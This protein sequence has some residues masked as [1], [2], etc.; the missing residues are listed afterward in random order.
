MN[1]FFAAFKIDILSHFGTISYLGACKSIYKMNINLKNI[2]Y[3]SIFAAVILSFW[4]LYYAEFFGGDY[5]LPDTTKIKNLQPFISGIA[6]PLMTFGTTLLVIETFKNNTLQNISNNFFKLID[7][8]R[9]I[10][11]GVN[12]DGDRAEDGY[13]KSK[14][15]NF[16]DDL[17]GQLCEDYYAIKQR[18]FSKLR[19]MDKSIKKIID[20]RTDKEILTDLYDHYFHVYQSDLGHY[21]RNLY[22]IVRYVDKSRIRKKEKV[23]FIKILRSQLSN[24]ELLILAYNGLHSYGTEFYKYLE[25]YELLKSLNN[26]NKLSPSYLKR[27]VDVTMLKACYPKNGQYW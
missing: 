5:H 16:F 14:G 22:Y 11:D 10:L 13:I 25:G 12:C 19:K 6:V 21:L 27:I 8:N 9:R 20:N 23:E 17:A 3:F 4:F 7:Q 1:L 15:K 2:A 24:Y 26:E 18:E